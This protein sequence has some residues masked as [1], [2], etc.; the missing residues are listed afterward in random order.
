MTNSE[1]KQVKDLLHNYAGNRSRMM[2]LAGEINAIQREIRSV[3][4]L[5]GNKFWGGI[6]YGN[7]R[8]LE[9]TEKQTDRI[10]MLEANLREIKKELAKT[11]KLTEKTEHGIS[12][13][14]KRQREVME[15]KFI[16]GMLWKEIADDLN[17]TE[18]T[19]Y[20]IYKRAVKQ[21][22]STMVFRP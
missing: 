9:C 7:Y 11:Q 10:I 4:D 20:R 1:E 6:S 22:A 21:L 3:A 13:L 14:D 12:S 5:Q 15:K 2:Y 16:G 18:R 19:C 17:I 8:E